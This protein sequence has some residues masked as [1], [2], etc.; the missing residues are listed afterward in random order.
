MAG[1]RIWFES[2]DVR[3]VPSAEA[4]AS[5]FLVPALHHQLPLRVHA[6]L[7]EVWQDSVARMCP[8]LHEWWGYPER[9]DVAGGGK[10]VLPEKQTALAQCFSGGAD[11]FYSLLRGRHRCQYLVYVHGYDIALADGHRMRRIRASLD[12]V[13]EALGRRVIVVS[14]NLRRHPFYRSMPW[15]HANGGALAAIGHLLSGVIGGLVIPSSYAYDDHGPCGSHFLTDAL[16]SSE[17]LE[18]IHDEARLYRLQKLKEIDDE[19]LVRKHLRVC[20]EN[21]ATSGNC[22]RCDKCVRTMILL[23][24]R[25]RLQHFPVFDRSTP[26][27]LI[28]DRMEPALPSLRRRYLELLEEDLPADV[29]AGIHRLLARENPPRFNR[30]RRMLRRLKLHLSRFLP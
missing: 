5:A 14:T 24:A 23:L 21:R 4:F 19:P 8:I 3:L 13:A 1:E 18:I 22:S 28:L 6:P 17:N 9:A 27:P 10:A 25:K 30:A 20:W 15:D 7:S 16:W 11:S 2:R 26:L 12:A 29:V